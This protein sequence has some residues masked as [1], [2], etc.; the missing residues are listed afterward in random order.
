MGSKVIE[1]IM[2]RFH[3]NGSGSLLYWQRIQVGNKWCLTLEGQPF[4]PT[5][6][7]K[8]LKQYRNRCLKHSNYWV[9][10]NTKVD[11]EWLAGLVAQEGIAYQRTSRD[12]NQFWGQL[13]VPVYIDK[14]KKLAGVI[15]LAMYHPEEDYAA[16]YLQLSN[17]LEGE[18]LATKA[19]I[20]KVTYKK[21]AIKF[22]LLSIGIEYLWENVTKLIS[23]S[24]RFSDQVCQP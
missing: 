14:G 8:E 2:N 21:D 22:P 16:D 12:R 10:Q 3:F 18:N 6:D 4:L 7:R 24:A 15:E 9:G 5:A 13:G 20:V 17:L 11:Q 19:L 23:G 1:N